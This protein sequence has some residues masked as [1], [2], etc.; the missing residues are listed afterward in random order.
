[1]KSAKTFN[2]AIHQHE[3][4]L[5]ALGG[6]E[7]DTCERFDLYQNKWDIISSY[8]ETVQGTSELNG[9]CQIYVPGRPT[10]NPGGGDMML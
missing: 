2:G 8:A 10:S 3:N 6:N 5:F 1:M 7:R 9:W 4:Y